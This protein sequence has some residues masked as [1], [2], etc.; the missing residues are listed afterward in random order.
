M[1]PSTRFA[2]AALIVLCSV[3]VGHA[4]PQLINYQALLLDGGG[5]PVTTPISKSGS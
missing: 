4:I 5:N 3:T 2:I 1:R